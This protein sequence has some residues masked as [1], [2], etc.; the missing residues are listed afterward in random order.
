MPGV[1]FRK[2]DVYQTAVRF[3]PL[4]SEIADIRKAFM[5]IGRSLSQ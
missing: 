3:L 5:R 1:N 2:L 4:A